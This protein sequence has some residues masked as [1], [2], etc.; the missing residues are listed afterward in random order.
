[1]YTAD[2]RVQGGI[3]SSG[4][5][6]C[7]ELSAASSPSVRLHTNEYL[8]GSCKGYTARVWKGRE[9]ALHLGSDMFSVASTSG[10]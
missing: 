6:I 9:G 8:P 5:H 4:V 2:V 3:I 1:M 10:L 7:E